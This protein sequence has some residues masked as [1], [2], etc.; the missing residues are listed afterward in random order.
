MMSQTPSEIFDTT[1]GDAQAL[2]KPWTS[3]EHGLYKP[4]TSRVAG[5]VQALYK[6]RTSLGGALCAGATSIVRPLNPASF[7]NHPVTVEKTNSLGPQNI[8]RSNP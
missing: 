4:S 7:P 5:L 8:L 2:H 1:H 6:H 3:L